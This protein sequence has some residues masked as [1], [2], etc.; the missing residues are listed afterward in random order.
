MQ[1]NPKTHHEASSDQRQRI[2]TMMI[3]L[4]LVTALV[5]QHQQI[6]ALR[7][8]IETLRAARA[9]RS[10]AHHGLEAALHGQGLARS[11]GRRPATGT[12]IPHMRQV[13]LMTEGV[14][15]A[16]KDND[17][18]SISTLARSMLLPVLAGAFA[19]ADRTH[20]GDFLEYDRAIVRS[21]NA[22]RAATRHG[23]IRIVAP[24]SAA[25]SWNQEFVASQPETP[26]VTAASWRV[27]ARERDAAGAVPVSA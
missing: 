12:L 11:T 14:A 27:H 13:E 24:G 16:G 19:A 21:Y 8:E 25:A 5:V 2:L 1:S 20:R 15:D 7:A 26:P 22:C 6:S 18:G 9:A 23:Y 17:N 4:T 10:E 3:A